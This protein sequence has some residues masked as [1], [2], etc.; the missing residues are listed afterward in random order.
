MK[1]KILLVGPINDQGIGGR[2]EE[3]RV[4]VRFL[5]EEQFNVSVFSMFNS[6]FGL[7]NAKM[8]ESVHLVFPNFW[9]W[10]PG[11]RNLILRVWSSRFF[12]NQ[13]DNFYASK[14]W[15]VFARSFNH[16]ILF[17]THQSREIKIF[18]SS[19][20]VAVSI[21]FTGTVHD[22]SILKNHHKK[23]SKAAR[24]YVIHAPGLF[25]GFENSIPKV[26]IDQTTLAEKLLLHLKI[27]A[28]LKVFAMIGL[29]M[30]VKQM[31][32]VINVFA[33]LPN[34]NLILFGTGELQTSYQNQIDTLGLSNVKIAGFVAPDQIALLY[35]QIDA[36]IINSSEETGPMT[37]IEAMASGKL[38]L[39]R[40]VGAMRERLRD[41]EMIFD[42]AEDLIEKIKRYSSL[43]PEKIIEYKTTLRTRYLENY[44]NLQVKK[45]I[46][47]MLEGVSDT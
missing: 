19:L 3:M 44:S 6:R 17:I 29:F 12:R 32:E 45:Q 35:A 46:K 9:S 42:K 25:Y 4:W 40:P 28:N 13:R 22:F 11:L 37:G 20:P 41:P 18:D 34:L 15:L 23:L 47:N 39:S 27:D 30:E 1:S 16:I 21:R 38:I 2:F 14:K 24:N 33:K 36:L 8:V 10:F 31:E 26:Y 5:E 43:P 7:E